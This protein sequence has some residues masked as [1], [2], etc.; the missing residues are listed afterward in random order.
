MTPQPNPAQDERIGEF[1]RKHR[2]GL[3]TLVFTD[4]VGSTARKQQLGDRSSAQVF[5]QHHQI[6]RETLGQFPQGEEIETAG[7]SF[8]LAFAA[9]SEAVQFALLLQVRLRRLS[10]P[11]S[12]ASLDRIGI[13]LGEVVLE[14]GPES[15]KARSIFGL[16]IDIC[17][18]VM[19]LAEGG[20]ILMTRAVFDSAR[21]A[22]KGEDIAEVKELSWLNH[23]PYL[24]KGIGESVEV[25]LGPL[26]APAGSEKAQRQVSPDRQVLASGS[27]FED[28]TIRVWDAATG[29]L[30]HRLYDGHTSFVSQLAFTRDGRRLISSSGGREA[31][32]LWD[33]GTRQ[34]LLALAGTYYGLSAARWSADGEV[35]LAGPPWQAWRAPSWEEIAAAEAKE[36][37]TSDFG[38]PRKADSKQP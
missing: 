3:V 37:P 35:I 15:R 28:P 27:G 7:D 21:Q 16:A 5:R 22:L 31:V 1:Q 10:D 2:T 38:E 13:Y 33:V 14:A 17:A 11:P 29:K 32:K 20:Q 8:L 4:M 9:P 24:L 6:V 36:P 19:G 30:L 25:G 26:T 12:A 18:R 23:G 34:E